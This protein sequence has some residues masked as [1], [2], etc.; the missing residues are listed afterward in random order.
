VPGEHG[1]VLSDPY[2][3]VLAARLRACLDDAQS[4]Q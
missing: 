3:D 2:V 1:D 4:A